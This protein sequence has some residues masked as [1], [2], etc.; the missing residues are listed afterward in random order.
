MITVDY[1]RLNPWR[2]GR[3]AWVYDYLE[4]N[5]VW[6]AGGALRT[7]FC[8]TE[9]VSDYD[10]FFR[11]KAHMNVVRNRLEDDG[12]RCVFACPKGE[13][14]TYKWRSVKVQL[15]AKRFY[16]SARDLIESFDFTV[17]QAAFDGRSVTLTKEMIKSVKTKKLYVNTITYPVAS[18]NRMMK[19]KEKGYFVGEDVLREIVTQIADRRF[20]DDELVL[21]VD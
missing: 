5:A 13:L 20:N 19:Y 9:A 16:S 14:F 3:I 1:L 11:S 6:V 8:P 7:M 15:I 18:L 21:Y 2:L 12:F 17:C 4:E 10:L